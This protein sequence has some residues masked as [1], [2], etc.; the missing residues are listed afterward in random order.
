MGR[1]YPDKLMDELAEKRFRKTNMIPF[2]KMLEKGILPYPYRKEDLLSMSDIC[3][4][5][6]KPSVD[7]ITE[8]GK[9][10]MDIDGYAPTDESFVFDRLDCY[11]GG[12]PVPRQDFTNIALGAK[13]RMHNFL[14]I[15][16]YGLV[17]TVP[18][19]INMDKFPYFKNKITTDGQY[20]YDRQGKKHSAIKYRPQLIRALEESARRL[21]LRLTGDIAWT[22]V[23]LDP[24]HIRV[25]LI[26]PGY[27][28]PADRKAT[29]HF[30]H[31]KATKVHDILA[32]K[33]LEIVNDSI[34]LTVP[35]GI[36]RVVDITHK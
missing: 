12:A 28:N 29:I 8:H 2:Y 5:I 11:W 10:L 25:T 17:T 13:R 24:E 23:R 27:L 1:S 6:T 22:A 36:L 19:G 20:Y 18:D 34:N 9:N 32:G 35:L 14:P 30:Q 26:D 16:P 4:G 31:L 15:T 21:P 33:D 3:L 7:Y